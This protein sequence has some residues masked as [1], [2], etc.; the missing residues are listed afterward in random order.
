MWL[1]Q[2]CHAQLP[3][4]VDVRVSRTTPRVSEQGWIESNVC[5][6]VS[7]RP[8]KLTNSI[9]EM[10]FPFAASIKQSL[11]FLRG[12]FPDTRDFPLPHQ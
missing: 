10:W 2:I 5:V 9:L 1:V 8:S 12:L 7:G 11:I 6:V 3:W 4:Y